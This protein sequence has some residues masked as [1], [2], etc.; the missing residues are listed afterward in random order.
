ME[1]RHVVHGMLGGEQVSLYGV[2]DGH[3]G[4]QA[5]QYCKDHVGKALVNAVEF[6]NDPKKA[7]KKAI[8]SVD[9]A[10]LNEAMK[11]NR[12]DGTTLI[13]TMVTK[14]TIT[15]ANVGDSRAV[16]VK[17]DGTTDALS[18]DHVR[19]LFFIFFLSPIIFNIIIIL[20]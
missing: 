14:D 13:V 11:H 5:A 7:L 12:D 6:P 1:D 15:C 2:F 3:G 10:Y 20:F 4:S 19:F 8:L 9:N 16:L 18:Y 17:C